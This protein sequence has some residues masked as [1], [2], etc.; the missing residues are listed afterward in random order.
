MRNALGVHSS[1]Y[2]SDGRSSHTAGPL[3]LVAGMLTLTTISALA[4]PNEVFGDGVGSRAPDGH[5]C[6]VVK[7]TDDGFLVIRKGPDDSSHGLGRLAP[8]DFV[9][10]DACKGS[11]CDGGWRHVTHVDFTNDLTLAGWVIADFWT[12]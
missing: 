7:N 2:P 4:N 5:L 10:V 9:D 8:H 11:L 3:W 1:A 6:A 12:R